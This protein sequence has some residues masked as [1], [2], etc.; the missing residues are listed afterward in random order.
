MFVVWLVIAPLL[1][2]A[3][4]V[5]KKLE[6]ADA[7]LVLAGSRAYEERTRKAAKVYK[8]GIASKIFLTDDG[9]FAG[10]S[11]KEERNPPFVDL[12]KRELLE[13]GVAQDDIEIFKPI[14][15]GTIYEAELIEEVSRVQ[16]LKSILLITS[17]Y[18][19][20]RALWTF[21]KKVF[22][23]KIRFGVTSPDKSRQVPSAYLWWLSPK[24]W[25]IVGGEY[26]KFLV[27]WLYY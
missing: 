17:P 12:A 6:K 9:G 26:P 1:A 14:G 27:Y 11:Q 16:N 7:I 20:R 13:Q 4:I 5:E 19:T 18:H 10:W 22:K 15:S 24:G 3:L 23:G 8:K 21:E 2:K 25:R